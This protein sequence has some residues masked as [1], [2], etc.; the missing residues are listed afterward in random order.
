MST[1]TF[2]FSVLKDYTFVI[3]SV[4]QQMAKRRPIVECIAQ[5]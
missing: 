3:V 2:F 5:T 1:V 4:W